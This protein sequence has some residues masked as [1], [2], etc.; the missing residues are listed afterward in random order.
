LAM[1]N[2]PVTS[3]MVA[4]GH[5]TSNRLAKLPL[6]HG[7]DDGT[8][9]MKS[10]TANSNLFIWGPPGYLATSFREVKDKGIAKVRARGLFMDQVIDVALFGL[11]PGLS[12]FTRR[13]AAGPL[14]WLSSSGMWQPVR[15][16]FSLGGGQSPLARYGPNNHLSF[17]IAPSDHFD[18]VPGD[19]DPDHDPVYKESDSWVGLPIGV[20]NEE[21]RTITN[22]VIFSPTT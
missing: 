3:V 7:F 13:V 10:Q 20:N 21:V 15:A 6:L 9:S 14:P 17:I 12:L 22:P 2:T 5:P 8:L 1:N 19:G 18:T 4:G 11:P 16:E